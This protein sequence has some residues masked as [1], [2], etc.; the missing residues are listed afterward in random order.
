MAVR[1]FCD[2]DEASLIS[3]SV[4]AIPPDL[5]SSP[6]F[7]IANFYYFGLRGAKQDLR[8]AVKYYEIAGDYNHWEGGGRAG[9]MHVWGIGWVL[10]ILISSSRSDLRLTRSFHSLVDGLALSLLDRSTNPSP[11]A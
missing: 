4:A 3:P 8:L 5:V 6:A 1:F 11:A 10:F 2:F 9:L 7:T